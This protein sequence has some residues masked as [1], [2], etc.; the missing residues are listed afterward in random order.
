MAT[1]IGVTLPLLSLSMDSAFTVARLREFVMTAL[2]D[3]ALRDY[4]DA[5]TQAV[6]KALG[7]ATARDRLRG[8]TGDLVMLNRPA[9]TIT[10]VTEEIG[11]SVVT[12]AADDHELSDSGMVLRRLR[13][14]T[15]PRWGWRDHVNVVYVRSAAAAERIRMIVALVKLDLT[16]AG[17]L[18]SERIGDWSVTYGSV[19]YEDQ[20]DRILAGAGF[21]GPL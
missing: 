12:L 8:G 11:D 6:D 21:V 14:G 4:L 15:N 17:A 13:T 10:S 19:A 16:A 20:R 3:A 18:T 7:P 1:E 5:A 9:E 2:S